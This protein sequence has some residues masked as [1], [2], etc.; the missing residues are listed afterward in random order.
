[1]ILILDCAAD[2]NGLV[3]GQP[4]VSKMQ[5]KLQWAGRMVQA[6][7][8]LK[9][10]LKDLKL[11]VDTAFSKLESRRAN[12]IEFDHGDNP[13]DV[14]PRFMRRHL[15]HMGPQMSMLAG[16]ELDE[17]QHALSVLSTSVLTASLNLDHRVRGGLVKVV[18][19][20]DM[21]Q[22]N[23]TRPSELFAPS[24][25]TLASMGTEQFHAA[26]SEMATYAAKTPSVD[27]EAIKSES[28]AKAEHFAKILNPTQQTS[29]SRATSIGQQPHEEGE[30]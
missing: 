17:V 25:R 30:G 6:T 23:S 18:H 15:M 4:R 28:Q 20:A 27:L 13:C 14:S 11:E 9:R 12:G 24:I 16:N 5:Y 22:V 7:N 2:E 21:R 8:R 10:A 3:A 29:M 26:V 19:V 1:M